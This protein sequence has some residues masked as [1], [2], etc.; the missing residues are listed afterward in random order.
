MSINVKL[1]FYSPA[2]IPMPEDGSI[3]LVTD[4]ATCGMI[5][6]K[7][8]V[9]CIANQ[10]YTPLTDT[11]IK[12]IKMWSSVPYLYPCSEC[13]ELATLPVSK[14]LRCEHPNIFK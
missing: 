5:S 6:F 8:G 2:E 9:F 3:V 13:G 7:N 11:Q 10:H 14:C 4:G 12:R 1:T